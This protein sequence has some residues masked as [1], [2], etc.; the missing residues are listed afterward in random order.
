ML[1]PEHLSE[2]ASSLLGLLT[3]L[4]EFKKSLYTVAFFRHEIPREAR[5]FWG[6]HSYQKCLAEHAQRK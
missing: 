4:P 1:V 5:G 6:G 3:S 2:M